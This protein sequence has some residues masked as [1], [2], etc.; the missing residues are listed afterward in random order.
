MP[1]QP[2]VFM[3]RRM[4]SAA[5]IG[6]VILTG[7]GG[8]MARQVAS[9]SARSTTAQAVIN[10]PDV[11][12]YQHPHGARIAWRKVRAA[13]NDFAIVKATEGGYYRNPWFNADYTGARRAGLVRGS[14]HF[15]RPQQPIVSSARKQ[16]WYYVHRLGASSGTTR[17]LPPALDLEV[18]GGLGRAELVTWAQSFLLEARRLTGRVPMLYTYPSFYSYSL[19]DP[20]AL[21]RYP[22]WMASYSR[23][24]KP[25][26]ATLWQYT[27]SAHV[28]GI[29]GGVDMSRL[30]ASPE[31]WQ[32]LINGHV[33]SPWPATVPGTPQGLQVWRGDGRL[34]VHWLPGDAGSDDITSYTVTAQPSGRSV[35]VGGTTFTATVPG[36][37]NGVGY[38]VT[39]TPHNSAGAGAT[40]TSGLVVPQVPTEFQVQA[41]HTLYGQATKVRAR[42]VRSDRPGAL[43]GQQVSV[44]QRSSG[45][46]GWTL[47]RTATTDAHGWVTLSLAHPTSSAKLLFA[48][49]A[50]P[51]GWH[52]ARAQAQVVVASRASLALSRSHVPTRHRVTMS[53]AIR[54]RVPGVRVMRQLFYRGSWHTLQRTRTHEGG[55]YAFAFAVRAHGTFRYRVIVASFSGLDWGSSRSVLL[56]VRRR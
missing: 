23:N 31:T 2:P 20:A 30:L 12:S 3:L 47:L 29:R 15:A 44:F 10:G 32:T 27:A 5:V 37:T 54:P 25:D 33:A 4:V 34:Y 53:G 24:A 26:N 13:R 55:S 11:S 50:A 19:G 1:P 56:H 39:V 52:A 43:A 46:S 8:A 42:L 48:Y 28:N 14:Y 36:L 35:T 9:S 17:T 38:A 21:S 18:T 22:L 45:Q 51:K 41:P 6:V 49:T 40:V 16:A 7:V